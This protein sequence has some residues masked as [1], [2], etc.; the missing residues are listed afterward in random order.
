MQPIEQQVSNMGIP[1]NGRR[2]HGSGDPPTHLVDDAPPPP[3]LS[4]EGDQ[5]AR[6][7]PDTA[8][9]AAEGSRSGA[10]LLSHL[11]FVDVPYQD[12]PVCDPRAAH[13]GLQLTG[14]IIS[15]AFCIPY[16]LGFC[17]EADWV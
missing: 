7:A 6:K 3:V 12:S 5:A 10:E 2:D 9:E 8:A 16:K 11:S 1:R 13:P 15:A 17:P 4:Y 14:R